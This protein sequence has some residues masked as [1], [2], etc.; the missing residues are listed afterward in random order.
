MTT[1]NAGRPAEFSA[2][3]PAPRDSLQP[4]GAARA[5]LGTALLVQIG[6]IG[7][8]LLLGQLPLLV[9]F[10][11][12]LWARPQYQFF[13]IALVAA[14][15]IAWERLREI[16]TSDIS[17]GPLR[18]T[19]TL[20]ALAWIILA[21]GLLYLRWM[22]PV[23]A[24]LMLAAIVMW[25]GGW[26]LARTLLPAA[27]LLII[28]IPPPGHTDEV[29]GTRLRLWAVYASSRLL[30]LFS[31]PHVVTGTL[32]DI[33]GHRL[34]IEEAC[35]G[36]NSL[37]SVIAFSL[38][39]GFWQRRR[40]AVIVSLTCAAAGF[41]LC[42]NIVRITLGAVLVHYWQ[43]DILAGSAHEMLGI[44]LFAV[45]LGLVISFD[46]FLLLVLP[47]SQRESSPA[48]P[49]TEPADLRAL[50]RSASGGGRA[51]AV[52]WWAAAIAFAVLGI[53][54]QVRVGNAWATSRL[55]DEAAF[56]LPAQ[57]GPWQRVEGEGTLSGRPETDGRK[58]HFWVYRS[59]DV[60][61]GVAMDYPFSGFH[62]A[63]LCYATAGWI[64]SGRAEVASRAG[65]FD[66]FYD[67]RMSK[68]LISGELLFALFDEHGRP[69]VSSPAIAGGFGNIRGDLQLSKEKALALPTYQ[70]QTLT[71][72]YTP[73]TP[74][75]HVKVRG[76][77]LAARQELARQLTAQLEGKP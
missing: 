6:A 62:D 3:L 30:D 22:A 8:L 61:A 44:V 49:P 17:R 15:Y 27:V 72:G 1:A 32:I 50:A 4:S 36:I 23:S 75:Q 29:L 9:K 13:P 19:A 56:S 71:L 45:S 74:E 41:V 52:M 39:Y 68:P 63:T 7:V 18:V 48:A 76:L 25:A 14:G 33:P 10:F 54:L 38:L 60:T 2:E 70:V 31:V 11:Q 77:F 66:G 35:S 26:K 57:I 28:I 24:W 67:V 55:G 20:L 43:V 5:A 51:G 64:I 69:P 42:A 65:Q 46:R 53:A 40:A 73:L 47:R 21:G 16:S 34:L 37:M 58:S 59:G 12:S